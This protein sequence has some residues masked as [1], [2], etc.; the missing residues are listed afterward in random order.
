MSLIQWQIPDFTKS[1]RKCPALQTLARASARLKSLIF[2][3]WLLFWPHLCETR[4]CEANIKLKSK[5]KL[6]Q[7]SRC[8]SWSS[9]CSLGKNDVTSYRFSHWWTFFRRIVSHSCL[10]V[11]LPLGSCYFLYLTL[12]G[13]FFLHSFRQFS[14][15]WLSS[16]KWDLNY[17]S[18]LWFGFN[19]RDTHKWKGFDLN[20]NTFLF[21]KK[22]KIQLIKKTPVI[23]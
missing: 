9:V 6:K 18:C 13:R 11:C 19:K 20:E 5:V 15:Q 23:A 3:E 17:K 2:K 21:Q 16:F 22:K 8:N 14:W 4:G 1:F 7:F 10:Y 12:S